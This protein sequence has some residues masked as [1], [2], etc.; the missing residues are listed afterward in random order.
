MA[1]GMIMDRR[2]RSVHSSFK[3]AWEGRLLPFPLSSFLPSDR[4]SA[5]FNYRG[6]KLED[7]LYIYLGEVFL[8]GNHRGL[9]G[10]ALI[11]PVQFYHW[12]QNWLTLSS[13]NS[14]PIS[15]TRFCQESNGTTVPIPTYFARTDNWPN[16]S[17]INLP[18]ELWSV[19]CNTWRG[20]LLPRYV[21][22][23]TAS[24]MLKG[25]TTT[26]DLR[27]EQI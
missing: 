27:T 4:N 6:S 14:L 3:F 25:K 22:L 19:D 5:S 12:I 9:L 1:S 11:C 17:E 7:P 13:A 10:F 21:L 18:N 8:S 15:T 20:E 26:H 24:G 16:G 2:F 23:P